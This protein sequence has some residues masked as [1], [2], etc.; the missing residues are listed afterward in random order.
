[1]ESRRD[2]VN[3]E[4]RRQ[5][6][7][8]PRQTEAAKRVLIDLGQVLAQY[9]DCMVIVGGWVPDLLLADAEESHIGS[10]D[11]DLALDAAKLNDGR[12]AEILQLLLNTKRYRKGAKDFQLVVTVDLKDG[13]KEIEV[14]VEFLA[15]KEVKLKKHS[16]KLLEGFRVLQADACGVAFQSPIEL[17]LK[18]QSVRGAQ[19]TVTMRVASIADFVIMKAHAIGGRDKPKDSYDLCYCLEYYPGGMEALAEVWRQRAGE[20]EVA[21]AT[22]ILQEKFASVDAFGPYQLVEFHDAPDADIQ[23]MHARRA[24]ELVQKFLSLTSPE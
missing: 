23:A 24:Y 13:E 11:V 5:E 16:P 9:K 2:N 10:I 17:T 21:R 20:K 7:Y 12:Y 14:E 22:E 8:S 3:D 19:N 15:P 4:R 18:G 6:E 1:M